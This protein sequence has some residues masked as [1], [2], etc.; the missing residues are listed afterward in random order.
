MMNM[1]GIPF[2]GGDI[3]GF[4]ET[5]EQEPELCTRWH[6]V[7]AFQ[8]FSRNHR[9]CE[10]KPIEPFRF[11]E[12]KTADNTTYTQIIK[13]AILDKYSLLRYYYTQLFLLSTDAEYTGTFYK[14]TFFEFP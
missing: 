14:P 7:G 5:A 11:D 12:F 8:P 2:V 1:F 10:S 9:D 4:R 13:K 3:C 6:Q